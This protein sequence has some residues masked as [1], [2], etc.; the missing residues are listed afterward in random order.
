M[1]HLTALPSSRERWNKRLIE[2]IKAIHPR[3]TYLDE[4]RVKNKDTGKE[5]VRQI[6]KTL[7]RKDITKL[8][9][10][11]YNLSSNRDKEQKKPQEATVEA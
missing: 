4:V 10:S 2:M 11:N 7:S 1:S 3:P 9:T 6:R 5:E 8:A